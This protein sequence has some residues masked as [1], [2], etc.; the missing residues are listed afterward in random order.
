MVLG[1]GL[2]PPRIAP[3]GPQPYASASSATRALRFSFS[4]RTAAA[5]ALRTLHRAPSPERFREVV[6]HNIARL[7]RHCKG[8]SRF[9]SENPQIFRGK[10][11]L[12][13]SSGTPPMAGAM[14]GQAHLSTIFLSLEPAS[15]KSVP[16]LCA[17]SPMIPPVSLSR[18]PMAP[19]DFVTALETLLAIAPKRPLTVSPIG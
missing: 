12:R 10:R 6:K 4:F 13:V 3:Y 1:G 17:A 11:S 5:A 19:P 18:P 14:R 9:F 8:I 15:L 7:R 16:V 2:E